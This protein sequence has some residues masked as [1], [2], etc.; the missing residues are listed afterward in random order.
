MKPPPFLILLTALMM[1]F[2]VIALVFRN[3]LWTTI[4]GISTI[5]VS[6]FAQ[7]QERNS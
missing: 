2:T 4:F 1:A 5:I 6:Y 7:Q 3:Q